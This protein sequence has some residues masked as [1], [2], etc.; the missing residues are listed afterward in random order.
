M[1][2][3]MAEMALRNAQAKVE[4]TNEMF[5][6]TQEQYSETNKNLLETNKMLN[7][8][9]V[10]ISKLDASTASLREILAMLKRVR[11]IEF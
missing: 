2:H 9:L 6:N 5:R 11:F 8:S 3:A 7:Q 1:S 4:T 10:E